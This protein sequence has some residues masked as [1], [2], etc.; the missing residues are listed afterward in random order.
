M[1]LR[2]Y[3][4]IQILP[5]FYLNISKGGISFSFGPRGAHVTV[6]NKGTRYTVGAPGTGFSYTKY[7]PQKKT[8]GKQT[9]TPGKQSTKSNS[10]KTADRS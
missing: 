4:R 6:G 1:G 5:G 3:K 10:S 8:T 2:F 7:S 9:N